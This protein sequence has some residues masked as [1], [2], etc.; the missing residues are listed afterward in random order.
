MG[1]QEYIS[2]LSQDTI[3]IPE[4][5]HNTLDVS[6]IVIDSDDTPRLVPLC[7]LHLP[8][9]TQGASLF[10]IHCRAQ[11]N[12]TSWGP[13]SI[14]SSSDRPFCDKTEDAIIIFDICYNRSPGTESITFILHRSALLA[15]VPVAPGAY[16]TFCSA[17]APE[18]TAPDVVHVPWSAWGPTTTRWFKG[19]RTSAS[20]MTRTAGQRAVTVGDSVPSPTIPRDFNPYAVRAACAPAS[21]SGKS[22]QGS[23]SMQLPNGNRMTVNVMKSVLAAG[24]IFK[25]DVRSSLP[26]VEIVTQN[27]YHYEGVM[28]DDQ[29]IL[30]FNVRFVTLCR[31]PV[32]QL[33]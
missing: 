19:E 28:I 24:P 21:T 1:S 4:L 3:V 29:R 10:D 18:G 14:S 15:H 16:A 13:I 9:L 32:C 20:W 26:Y 33:Y 11:P 27:K 30:G 5:Y 7:V 31:Q 2:F 8:P 6:K 23:W 25:E 22:Q 12:P 17:P